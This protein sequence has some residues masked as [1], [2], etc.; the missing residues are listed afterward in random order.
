MKQ[1][2]SFKNLAAYR[3]AAARLVEHEL[4]ATAPDNWKKRGLAMQEAAK[5]GRDAVDVSSAADAL[6]PLGSAWQRATRS[7]GGPTCP[8]WIGAEVMAGAAYALFLVTC[9]SCHDRSI[10]R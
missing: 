1:S 10:S 6:G 4:P 2:L 7:S 5:A 9:A 8:L 3:Q